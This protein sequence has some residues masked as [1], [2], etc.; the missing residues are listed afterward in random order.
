MILSENGQIKMKKT[1]FIFLMCVSWGAFSA[2][3]LVRGQPI[4]LEYNHDIYYWPNNVA[5]YPGTQNLFITMD[6]IN[7]LCFLNTAPPGL[8]EQISAIS[9][10]IKG[11]L[12]HWNCFPYTTE[13]YEVRP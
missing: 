12:T 11:Q 7:K 1:L 10:N 13:I 9:I 4:P 3:I 2:N 6:G 5:L 8:L